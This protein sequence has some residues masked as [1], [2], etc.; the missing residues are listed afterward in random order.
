MNTHFSHLF[1]NRD[2][3]KR[4]VC[5]LFALSFF[6]F[7]TLAQEP[8]WNQFRGPNSDNRS[9]STGIANS[10]EDGAPKLL[11]K[12]E[13]IGAGYSPVSFFGNMMFTMGDIDDQSFVFALDR[14]TGKEIWRQPV[15]RA[16]SGLCDNGS[17]RG[18]RQA[19][20]QSIGPL[21]SPACDGEKVFVTSQFGD[22]VVFNMKDGKELWR[23]DVFKDLQGYT[24]GDWGYSPSPILDG[25]TILLPIG[26][27]GGTLAA[28]DK[29]GKLLWRSTEIKDPAGYTSAV[30]VEIGGVRQSL[31]LTSAHIA[32]ISSAD[33]KVLWKSEFP[34]REAVCSD[35][36]LVGDVV[37][38]SGHYMAGGNFYRIT[39][40]G[41]NFKADRFAGPITSIQSHHGG[42]VAVDEHI[43]LL[44]SANSLVCV[45]AKT[46]NIVWT[47]RSVGK[48][49]MTY[50]DGKLIL[51][52]EMGDCTIAMVEATPEQ[53]RELGRF[54]QP[55]RSERSCYTYPVVAE[56][57]LYIRDQELLLCYDL[58]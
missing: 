40:E 21:S 54:D 50:V 38:A 45:E 33:G 26:G 48:G 16:G 53:Y 22:F 49:S 17:G 2:K 10:W 8:N 41:N 3:E 18:L 42:I 52:R 51:R 44:T 36:V 5:L 35:P 15:G 27:E 13:T 23:K 46:G 12:I 1:R 47:N 58:E 39:K 34:A 14:N 28:F 20:N 56:K 57:K 43:Y 6:S 55:Y 30:P 11:W 31:L 9:L 37:M 24:M 19:G 32:G 7:V 25:N 4:F 29:S